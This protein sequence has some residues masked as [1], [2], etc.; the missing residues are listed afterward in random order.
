MAIHRRAVISKG[1]ILLNILGILCMQSVDS[2]PEA[3][4]FLLALGI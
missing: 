3:N 4:F 1:E 2:Y